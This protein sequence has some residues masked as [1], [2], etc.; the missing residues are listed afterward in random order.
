ML[1]ACEVCHIPAYPARSFDEL[2][3]G[4]RAVLTGYALLRMHEEKR[5][6]EALR[7]GA[8]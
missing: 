8:R 6:A 5:L 7:G 4:Q 2:T 1:R 3:E